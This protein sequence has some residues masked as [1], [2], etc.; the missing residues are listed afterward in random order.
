MCECA[1]VS[2]LFSTALSS[3]CHSDDADS[4]VVM[5]FPHCQ[6]NIRM[7]LWPAVSLSPIIS[8]TLWPP[9]C[10]L[11]MTSRDTKTSPESHSLS[12]NMSGQTVNTPA[13]IDLI[14]Q[15]MEIRRLIRFTLLYYYSGTR[16]WLPFFVQA[17]EVISSSADPGPN[18]RCIISV[19]IDI[20]RTTH[21]L[22][23]WVISVTTTV[24]R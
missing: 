5:T 13:F 14:F 18:I 17:V 9:S 8:T 12:M 10:L 6:A 23:I 4:A 20:Q 7:S 16:Y 11:S 15:L 24:F 22:T 19:L 21:Y 1:P 2:L 3:P